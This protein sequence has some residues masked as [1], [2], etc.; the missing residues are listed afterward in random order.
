[1]RRLILMLLICVLF[2][3]SGCGSKVPEHLKNPRTEYIEVGDYQRAEYT[4]PANYRLIK[5]GVYAVLDDDGKV[6]GFMKLIQKDGEY[7]WIESNSD[8]AYK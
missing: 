4:V 6:I 1:V 3:L 5:D 2:V 8:E 7:K